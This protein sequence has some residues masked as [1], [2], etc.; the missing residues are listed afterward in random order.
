[1]KTTTRSLLLSPFAILKRPLGRLA[2]VAVIAS[3]VAACS[4]NDK[5]TAAASPVATGDVSRPVSNFFSGCTVKGN[6]EDIKATMGSFVVSTN[7]WN[8]NAAAG[9]N[10][11]VKAKV[12]NVTGLVDAQITWDVTG[13]NNEV[14]AYPNFGYGWQV[15]TEQGS[16]TKRLPARVSE[17]PDIQATGRIETV[18]SAGSSCTMNTAFEMLFSSTPTPTVWPPTAEVMVWMQATCG[19]CNAGKLQ[20]K[21]TID[22]VDFDVYKGVVTPPTGTA[23]WTYVA[24]VAQKTVAQLNFNMK[25]FVTDSLTR[26][27]LQPTDYLSVVEL[28]TEVT[29]GKGTTTITGYNVR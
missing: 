18:C 22:G 28:G 20:G 3:L 17:L 15:G 4:G 23:S 1:M 13:S 25:N 10:E 29:S 5:S 19:H 11:C 16:T 24:Y 14:L 7:V 21:V 8:P 12:D 26:G 6:T 9:F 2:V 27:Y